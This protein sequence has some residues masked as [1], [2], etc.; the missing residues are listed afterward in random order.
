[1]CRPTF[2][3]DASQESYSSWN[4]HQS[5]RPI[6]QW[7]S[8][9]TGTLSFHL[10]CQNW[11]FGWSSTSGHKCYFSIILQMTTP[12]QR[13]VHPLSSQGQGRDCLFIFRGIGKHPQG[14]QYLLFCLRPLGSGSAALAPVGTHCN[15]WNTP[16]DRFTPGHPSC[17]HC[18]V[19]LT[20][21]VCPSR[22]VPEFSPHTWQRHGFRP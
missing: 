10:P 3:V 4:C 22:T 16:R 18:I 20:H 7:L 9:L 8:W 6:D 19:V 11:H 14:H 5:H 21:Q 2:N 15:L 12:V 17:H 1:V 13:L